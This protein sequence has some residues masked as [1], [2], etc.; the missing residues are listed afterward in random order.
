MVDGMATDLV[1]MDMGILV[2]EVVIESIVGSLVKVSSHGHH[3]AVV[4]IFLVE[5]V[6]CSFHRPFPC[7]LGLCKAQSQLPFRHCLSI[8]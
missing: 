6:L 1:S 4:S 8:S 5:I 2:E 7:M 3:A